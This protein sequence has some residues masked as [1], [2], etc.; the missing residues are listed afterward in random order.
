VAVADHGVLLLERDLDGYQWS[1]RFFDTFI[2]GGTTPQVEVG[3]G[4][5]PFLELVGF[6]W[7]LAPVVSPK[8][9]VR[10]TTYW[11][12]LAPLDEGYRLAFY[13]L[14]DKGQ[15]VALQAEGPAA[16]WFPL[17]MWEPGQVVT[18]AL[19]PLPLSDVPH[20]GVALLRPGADPA[21]PDG[22]VVPITSRLGHA[23]PVGT[24]HGRRLIKP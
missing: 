4:F 12:A 19:S 3:A 15:A 20:L 1:P 17:W 18:V 22:R 21:D 2:A 14:D 5:G 13:H 16:S 23:S 8:P 10:V 7:A 9:L 11:R 6:D 24:G